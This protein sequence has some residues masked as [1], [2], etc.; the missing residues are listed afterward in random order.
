LE[1]EHGGGGYY[2]F[3]RASG[4]EIGPREQEGL[5]PSKEVGDIVGSEKTTG[6]ASGHLGESGGTSDGE[7]ADTTGRSAWNHGG[8]EVLAYAMT[9]NRSLYLLVS[10][11]ETRRMQIPRTPVGIC[12]RMAFKAV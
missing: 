9:G 10:Q 11:M 3:G 12:I 4:V 5:K 7:D 1:D 6:V 2:S 8:T